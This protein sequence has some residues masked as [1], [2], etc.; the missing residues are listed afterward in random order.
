MEGAL[1]RLSGEEGMALAVH[2]KLERS[3]NVGLTTFYVP[4]AG[5]LQG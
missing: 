1:Q 4:L 2:L 5:S 3:S